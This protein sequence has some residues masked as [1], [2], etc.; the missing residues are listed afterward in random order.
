MPAEADDMIPELVA[1]LSSRTSVS[2]DVVSSFV[3][4]T[5]EIVADPLLSTLAT[6]LPSTPFMR[7][8]PN[9]EGVARLPL[10]EA[11]E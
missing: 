7:N 4:S 1:P 2:L 11:K 5:P 3:E 6:V 8:F 10:S 9:A